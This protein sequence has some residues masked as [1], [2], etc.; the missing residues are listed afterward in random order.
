MTATT[1]V[2]RALENG[3]VIGTDNATAAL[4]GTNK[5]PDVIYKLRKRGHQI[6]TLTKNVKHRGVSKKVAQYRLVK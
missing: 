3:S 6:E 1:Q 2:L 4:Y 5:I